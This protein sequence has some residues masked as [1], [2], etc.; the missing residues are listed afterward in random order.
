MGDGTINDQILAK[1]GDVWHNVWGIKSGTFSYDDGGMTINAVEGAAAGG[2]WSI[3]RNAFVK[4]P[5]YE[6]SDIRLTYDIKTGVKVVNST[7][8][9]ATQEKSP[10]TVVGYL[11]GTPEKFLFTYASNS[12]T[13]NFGG[14]DEFHWPWDATKTQL[15]ENTDYTLIFDLV[16]DKNNGTYDLVGTVKKAAD[17][18]VV[19]TATIENWLSATDVLKGLAIRM[20]RVETMVVTAPVINIKNIKVESIVSGHIINF[21]DAKYNNDL[22]MIDCSSNTDISNA[23]A[24]TDSKYTSGSEW[25]SDNLGNIGTAVTASGNTITGYFKSTTGDVAK[26]FTPVTDGEVLKISGSV[27]YAMHAVA[28]GTRA[29]MKLGLAGT[30]ID[31]SVINMLYNPYW[32]DLMLLHNGVPAAWSRN[33]NTQMDVTTTGRGRYN[34]SSEW[35]DIED[36]DTRIFENQDG[37]GF[38]DRSN[39]GKNYSYFEGTVQFTFTAAPNATDSEKYD[40]TLTLAGG[41]IETTSVKTVDKALVQGMDSIVYK[42][43][44]GFSNDAEAFKLSDLKVEKYPAVMKD[45]LTVGTNTVYLPIENVT[46]HEANI[47]YRCCS[48]RQDNRRAEGLLH[49]SVHRPQQGNGQSRN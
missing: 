38:G 9:G 7:E 37:T 2:E 32:A 30:D 41:N 44:A 12:A 36:D 18:E 11:A 31:F 28:D 5:L 40:M 26:K 35:L 21:A 6:K 49:P 42:V 17:G 25:G 29:E 34:S 39:I 3:V 15:E 10:F 33:N 43:Y 27:M 20:R 13:L 14:S 24:T 8:E 4:S 48:L 47:C 19:K 23:V 46:G 22:T 45:G 1:N 16:Y